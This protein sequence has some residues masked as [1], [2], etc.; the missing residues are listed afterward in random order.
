MS[1]PA[2][3]AGSLPTLLTLQAVAQS[4]GFSVRQV[5]RWIDSGELAAVR[6]GRSLRVSEADL[7]LFIARKKFS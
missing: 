6:F 7:A 4:T 2:H 1:K 5:R 3:Q